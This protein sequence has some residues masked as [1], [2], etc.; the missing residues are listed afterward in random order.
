MEKSN[1]RNTE[2]KKEVKEFEFAFSKTNEP[3]KGIPYVAKLKIVEGKITRE[4]FNLERIWG[5][6]CVTVTGTFK[7]RVGDVVEQRHGGS[8]KY[9][10]RYWFI[11]SPSGELVKVAADWDSADKACVIKYLRGEI[12]L[13]DLLNLSKK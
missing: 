6:R 3:D 5:H 9:D 7:A 10:Y 11:V 2:E 1:V 13:S 12:S 4:F 8:R